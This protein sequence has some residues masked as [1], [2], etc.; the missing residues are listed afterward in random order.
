MNCTVLVEVIIS[1]TNCCLCVEIW[2]LQYWERLYYNVID[3]H[4]DRKRDTIDV[5]HNHVIVELTSRRAVLQAVLE[6]RRVCAAVGD[7]VSAVQY[8]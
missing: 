1:T 6:V 3:T 7:V 4:L 8:H 2:L 5:L